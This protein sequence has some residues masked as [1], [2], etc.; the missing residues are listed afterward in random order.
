MGLNESGDSEGIDE[1]KNVEL[2]LRKRGEAAEVMPA[3]NVDVLD[4]GRAGLLV[5]RTGAHVAGVWLERP[6]SMVIKGG[7]LQATCVKCEVAP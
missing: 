5:A 4:N 6:V 1:K 7:S 3:A 2:G